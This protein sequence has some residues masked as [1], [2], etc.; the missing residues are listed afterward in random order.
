ME[1]LEADFERV[2]GEKGSMGPSRF[3]KWEGEEGEETSLSGGVSDLVPPGH[4][5]PANDIGSNRQM[6]DA[7]FACDLICA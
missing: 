6:N 7:I 1:T 3:K 5:G 2:G 4:R